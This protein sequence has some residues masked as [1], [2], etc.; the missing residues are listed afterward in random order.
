MT[1][2]APRWRD[3]ARWAGAIVQSRG[4]VWQSPGRQL[5]LTDRSRAELDPLLDGLVEPPDPASAEM[6]RTSEQGLYLFLLAQEDGI[7]QILEVGAYW[8]QGSTLCLGLALKAKGRGRLIS[9]E[10]HPVRALRAQAF[11]RKNGLP[12]QILN[13]FSVRF[14]EYPDGNDPIYR[15]WS[16]DHEMDRD[17]KRPVGEFAPV[18]DDG[19]RFALAEYQMANRLDLVLLDGS[20][21]NAMAEFRIAAPHIRP[22]GY[23]VL[24][25]TNPRRS[26]KNVMTAA[27]LRSDPVWEILL[28][29]YRMRNGTLIARRRV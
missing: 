1:I 27:V 11:V 29:T 21:Y 8:G 6:T 20:E 7:D 22:G 9:L 13:R 19:I 25:D 28:D 14:D 23:L 18:P 5:P 16:D 17:A 26:R 24:D 3:L 10:S 2:K 12:A 4:R 15:G